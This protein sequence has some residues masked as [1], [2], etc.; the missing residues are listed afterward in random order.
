MKRFL[1]LFLSLFSITAMAQHDKPY[2][3]SKFAQLE[4]L[5]P[6][7][8]NYRTGSGAPG[9]E[10]WQQKADYKIKVALDEK[11]HTLT[12]AET[13][14]YYNYSPDNL[15]YLW[16]QVDQNRFK[17]GSDA[18]ET[19]NTRLTDGPNFGMINLVVGQTSEWG[20][21][22]KSVKDKSGK[23]MKYVI[24]KTMMR[25][26][27]PQPLKA[28]GGNVTFSI[29]W[30][31]KIVDAKKTNSRSGYE[32]FPKDGNYLYEIAQW[33]PRM[34]VY[35]DVNGW[36]HKQFLGNGEFALTF[37]DYE[38][39]ITA[40]ADHIVGATGEL[41]NAKKVLTSDQLNRLKK[42]A[43]ATSPVLI[44]DQKEV[45][46]KEKTKASGTKTWVFKAKN[47]R[48]FAWASSRKFI[49][50]AMKVKVGNN[51]IWAMSYY[52]KEGNPLWGKYSTQVVAHTLRTYSKYTFNYPYPVA[53]SVH[54]PIFGMEYP[55]ICFNGG[56]PRA[57]GTVPART[58]KAMISVI[59]HEVGHNYFPMIVNSDERQ[60]TWMDE[61]LNS[62]LQFLSEKEIPLQSWAKADYPKTYPHR[63]GPAKNIVRYMRTDPTKI[64][65]IMTNSESIPQFGNNAYGKPA[66]AL[67]ILREVVMGKELFDHAFKTYSQRWYF[68]HP[69]PADFFRTMEDAS[70]V[71]LD[72]FWRG[73]FY[74]TLPVDMSIDDVK[75]FTFSKSGKA[76]EAPAGGLKHE[77]F[78]NKKFDGL[79]ERLSKRFGLRLTDKE[80][81][82]LKPGKYYYSVKVKNIGGN[83]MPLFIQANFVDGSKQLVKVPA[84][85]FRKSPNQV[86][87]GLI[88]DKPVKS[89]ELDPNEMTADIDT[90]NNAFPR[91][92]KESKFKELKEK[93]SGSNK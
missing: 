29:E 25:I 57:D 36:Q 17:A 78:A 63:R 58:R 4:Q 88:F 76:A 81:A 43:S 89:F 6:T 70:G 38:V 87:K 50:D 91:A 65:P 15:K 32:Y 51:D 77:A 83:I 84:E 24:N 41:Q 13:I 10:Y 26:D 53:V 55:M 47:V 92:K 7:P 14:T 52:P 68:K 37:G 5:L 8:N 59:I 66:T 39:A 67:N 34:C 28:K 73:W 80:V 12:G 93:K 49:W 19:R 11:T 61:G 42:A 74:S 22:I 21:K 16:V 35:D 40:P 48:D 9:H 72:W 18:F 82:M 46:A 3:S 45:E 27:L 2:V 44:V 85:I 20:C 60:W 23:P 54:G 31:H 69:K 1:C 33:F 86:Y 75:A 56:R 79:R 62:F 30:A 64:V 71:D 90:K